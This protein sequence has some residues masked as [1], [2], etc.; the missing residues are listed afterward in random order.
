[1]I[2]AI[3]FNADVFTEEVRNKILQETGGQWGGWLAENI[4]PN[5]IESFPNGYIYYSLVT[6]KNTQGVTDCRND[7]QQF[8]YVNSYG[9][10]DTSTVE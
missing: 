10:K 8:I 4:Q 5:C 1:M 2:R 7:I 3:C 6:E 9:K